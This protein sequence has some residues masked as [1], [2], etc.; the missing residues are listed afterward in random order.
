M[1]RRDCSHAFAMGKAIS[2]EVLVS[3]FSDF[4]QVAL[5]QPGAPALV[6]LDGAV[7][8]STVLGLADRVAA[9]LLKSGLRRGD[10]VAV[11][12]GNRPELASVC[13]AC[14]RAGAVIVPVSCRLSGGDLGRKKDLI[15]A[16]CYSVSPLEV[17][18]VLVEHPDVATA[19]VFGVPD[20][21]GTGPG[22]VR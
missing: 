3:V 6:T 1:H 14:V 8:Y 16:D 21:A 4:Q 5:R 2:T 20:G 7:S 11:H 15:K 9:G 12:I 10:R 19:V 13:Y 18:R 22:A 17:E